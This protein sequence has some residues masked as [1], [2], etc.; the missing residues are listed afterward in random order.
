M[1]ALM[2]AHV[3]DFI[4]QQCIIYVY[5]AEGMISTQ[6]R[7]IK[8]LDSSGCFITHLPEDKGTFDSMSY[9]QSMYIDTKHS[10]LSIHKLQT[11]DYKLWTAPPVRMNRSS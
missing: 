7:V 9:S 4:Y 11:V 1:Y 8:I 2:Y 5:I 3:L 10:R 6:G